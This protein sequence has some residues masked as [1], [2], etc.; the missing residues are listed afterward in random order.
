[1]N[2]F[3]VDRMPRHR[4]ENML[5][6]EYRLA[7]LPSGETVL[8]GRFFWQESGFGGEHGYEW[9]TLETVEIE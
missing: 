6:T 8:Q 5:P 9:R 1:M 2:P 4:I 7:R 3:H